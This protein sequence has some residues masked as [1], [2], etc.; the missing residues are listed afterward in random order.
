MN[1]LLYYKP[2]IDCCSRKKK[3]D[4]SES[5]I[6][7]HLTKPFCMEQSKVNELQA[8]RLSPNEALI[9][10]ARN[11]REPHVGKTYSLTPAGF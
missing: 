3:S 7:Q 9:C 2:M 1:E 5:R 8:C 11:I 4:Q 6:T 10:P